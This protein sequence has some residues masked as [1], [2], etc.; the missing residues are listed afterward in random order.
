MRKGK[1]RRLPGVG[2][3]LTHSE[4][5]TDEII[6]GLTNLVNE[7]LGGE[8]DSK[9]VDGIMLMFFSDA[10]DKDGDEATHLQVAAAGLINPNRLDTVV[11]Y[12]EEFYNR[13]MLSYLAE[14]LGVRLVDDGDEPGV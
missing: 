5:E 6:A 8:I 14:S 10:I 9:N 3:Q 1:Y 12:I 7:R 13:M 11:S 4:A 2:K